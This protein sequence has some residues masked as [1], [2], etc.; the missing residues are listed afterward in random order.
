MN[1]VVLMGRLVKEPEVRYTQTGKVAA[2]FT[3]A[4][5]R[6]FTSQ[7]GQREADFI[8]CVIWGK[9]A[10]LMGNTVSKG[11]RVLVEGRIQVRSYKD[12]QGNNRYVTEVV[13]DGFEYIERKQNTMQQAPQ[14][15]PQAQKQGYVQPNTQNGY[16]VPYDEEIPF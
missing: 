2:S 14:M 3:L 15:P 4:I 9:S 12:N 8:P 7:N 11:Q 13:C 5:D 6:P 10:E 1:K 16:N